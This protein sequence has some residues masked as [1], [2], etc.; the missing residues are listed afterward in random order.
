MVRATTLPVAQKPF[1]NNIYIDGILWGGKYYSSSG[2]SPTKID[3]SF[4]NSTSASFDDPYSNYATTSNDWFSEGKDSLIKAL[5]TWAAVA[6]IQF[7]DAR[8]NNASA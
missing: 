4:W 6:N 8:D 7:V 1:T 2:S 3:N 5:D